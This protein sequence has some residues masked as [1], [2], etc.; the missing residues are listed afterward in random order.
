MSQR[1]RLARLEAAY[2]ADRLRRAAAAKQSAL[3]RSAPPNPETTVAFAEL[4]RRFALATPWFHRA[5][6][7][8][9]DDESLKRIFIMGPRLHAKTSCVLTYTLRRLCEDHQL[10]VG[11]I[12]QTDALAKH[13]LAEL[14]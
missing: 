6:Y 2:A 7:A 11:I 14:K 8:A 3:V 5:W 12:S 10:R 1:A 9:M 4:L 13:F